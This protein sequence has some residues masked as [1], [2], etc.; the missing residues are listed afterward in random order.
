MPPPLN[1]P[2][3]Q[4][5]QKSPPID[6]SFSLEH[7][8]QSPVFSEQ[9]PKEVTNEEVLPEPIVFTSPRT[10]GN[11]KLKTRSKK[12]GKTTALFSKQAQL[13]KMVYGRA[14]G[15]KQAWWDK[16][17]NDVPILKNKCQSVGPF[18]PKQSV[19]N[20]KPEVIKSIKTSRSIKLII[21]PREKLETSRTDI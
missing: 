11:L 21:T 16:S 7:N 2:K 10:R 9:D 1:K 13:N 20:K 17:G 3:Y 4:I 18:S 12:P 19:V 5:V 15:S 6:K 8:F 14:R